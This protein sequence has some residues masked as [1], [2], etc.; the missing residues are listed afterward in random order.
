MGPPLAGID[1]ESSLVVFA[2][3][4]A[5][6]K[7]RPIKQTKVCF[8]LCP[9]ELELD[10]RRAARSESGSASASLFKIAFI[11]NFALLKFGTR[12]TF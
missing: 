9:P 12:G 3:K 7:L 8:V 5:S 4:R 11:V 10:D 6:S 2:V 1:I